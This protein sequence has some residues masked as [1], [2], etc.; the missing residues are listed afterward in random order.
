MNR[1]ITTI[2]LFF[3]FAAT[4]FGYEIRYI[5]EV[6]MPL[7]GEVQCAYFD[8]RG[9]LWI[10]TN[11]GIIS[12]DGYTLYGYRSRLQTPRI[13][14][15][16]VIL[17]ITEDHKGNLWMG[18]RDGIV[19]RD[20]MTGKFKTYRIPTKIIYTMY[21]SKDGTV[22][23]GT[24]IGLTRYV[25]KTDSFFTYD[26]RTAKLRD[27]GGMKKVPVGMSVKSITE[28]GQG[29]I[30]IGTWSSGALML[31]K[32]SKTFLRY[33][34][35]NDMNSAFSMLY[36][37]RGK[38]W[39]GT[40]GHGMACI[41]NPKDVFHTKITRYNQDRGDFNTIYRMVEEPVNHTIWAPS[42]NGVS[43]IDMDKREEGFKN[44]SVADENLK[45]DIRFCNDLKVDEYGDVWMAT[46][47]RGILHFSTQPAMFRMWS[48]NQDKIPVPLNSVSSIFTDNGNDFWLGL[49][50][51]GLV[52]YNRSAG[53]TYFG[54]DIPGFGGVAQRTL[55][56]NFPSIIKRSNGE[57]WFSNASFGVLVKKPSGAIDELNRNN[58]DYISDDYVNVAY[59]T[60]KKVMLIGQRYSLGVLLPDGRGYVADMGERGGVQNVCDVRGI[61]E[62]SKG[63]IWLATED[64]GIIR[65]T[66]N[67]FNPKSLRFHYYNQDMGN[68]AIDDAVNCFEDSRGMIWAI[69]EN[70]GLFLYNSRKDFF[71]SVNE[72]FKIPDD[73]IFSINEDDFGN[74]WIDTDMSLICLKFDAHKNLAD[75]MSYSSAD[76]LNDILFSTNAT[77]K[78]GN[79]L[80][81]S[82]RYGFTSFVP[83]S[84]YNKRAKPHFNLV[85]SDITIDG[86]PLSDLDSA[87]RSKITQYLPISTRHLTIPSSV[88]RVGVEFALLSYTNIDQTKYIY[89]LEGYDNKWHDCKEGAHSASFENIP[90]GTYT[91][92]VKASDG[93]G[94]WYEMEPM[95]MEIL[96]PFYATWWA[97]FIYL[98]IAAYCLYAFIYVQHRI[99]I[100]RNRL[101]MNEVFTNITHELLTPLTVISASV[102]ELR[103][104]APQYEGNYSVIQGNI[105]K[106]RFMLRQILEVRKSQAGQLK[107]LVSQDDLKQFVSR[108]ISN[109]SPMARKK[110]I[111]I[112]F[113]CRLAEFIAWFDPDKVDKIIS[114][115]VSNSVKYCPEG[116]YV[117]V[118]LRKEGTNAVLVVADNGM[119]IPKDKMNNLYQRFLDGD[120]R[121]AKTFGTGIGLSLTRDLVVLHHGN[122]S[123]ESTPG[124]GTK[125]TIVFPINRNSFNEKE[126]DNDSKEYI[127]GSHGLM[128]YDM[129]EVE[130]S[131][132]ENMPALSDV[133]A[134][135]VL[136]VED[137]KQLL[138]LMKSL[139]GKKYHVFT[140][141]NGRRALDI[142][143][144]EALDLVISDI[145]MP[146][147][148]GIELTK[149]IKQNEDYGQL[150]VVLLTAK[151][152]DED[153]QEAYQI[154]ADS[155]ITKPFRL[156]VL[157]LRIDNIIAN[158]E[159][160]RK[161]FSSQTV[162]N[163][164]AEHYSSPESVLLQK[165]VDCV[166]AHLSNAD[167]SR[168]DFAA[169]MGMSSS[170]LYNKLRNLTGLSVS[171]FIANIRLKEACLIMDQCRADDHTIS[172]ADLS[173][174]VG[175][176]TPKYFSKC[177]K[178]EFG[179]TPSEYM[180][181]KAID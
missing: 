4:L 147:M 57:I 113:D 88:E 28:D 166:K 65:I 115:L 19:K 40:W 89:M 63:N 50:P 33:P 141:E 176:G 68:F 138:Q 112:N 124:K 46:Q 77:F 38:L 54:S 123:C 135:R 102:D 9:M 72:K 74:L 18:T 133:N 75:L 90:S 91:L 152:H 136:I 161:K 171:G 162:V 62:D 95:E 79:E 149:A 5:G 105:N 49:R 164:E 181:G 119:G 93:H 16:N 165:A 59:E 1:I 36:D 146:V 180:A 177:F 128:P 96:P 87:T 69:S 101:Q 61:M 52:Y 116:G 6:D 157:Q 39:V 108:E 122:I 78:Y 172:M 48:L 100:T 121:K 134:Y 167:Y 60:S 130:S 150:P 14:P 24:D 29:N 170:S 179:V 126:I 117:N 35:L 92:R 58:T 2:F 143:H 37:S 17:T 85:V 107:L 120:Y 148:D 20:G 99:M 169:D 22:W 144:R 94:D 178:D 153:R 81:F 25:P 174:K 173:V 64:E 110:N 103:G 86:A 84:T 155:Y 3:A 41:E 67:L 139:L 31:K 98:C 10:G 154:G 66:G 168:D 27:A 132:I 142:I 159:R 76:G 73:R 51:Y 21:T 30:Y 97:F 111:S 7:G 56:A 125:F 114:N 106:L 13:L 140:A 11:A 8:H 156:S 26:Y 131:E 127:I 175:F 15:N 163:V 82:N 129:P 158:R 104:N 83:V 71:E 23:I 53:T 118:S 32:G 151:T 45:K 47:N 34:K 55:N 80:Y 42:R 109:L 137:N 44:Y 70:G 160:V 12:Y 43:V 145:M